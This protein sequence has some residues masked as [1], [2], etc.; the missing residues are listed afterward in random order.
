[1]QHGGLRHLSCAN[2]EN[3]VK[4]AVGDTST[5]VVGKTLEEY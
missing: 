2:E 1:M 4:L 3:A 5:G